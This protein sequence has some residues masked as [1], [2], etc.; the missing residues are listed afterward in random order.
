MY[1]TVY[2]ED[3]QKY[4]QKGRQYMHNRVKTKVRVKTNLENNRW[5]V[6]FVSI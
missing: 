3:D 2:S 6:V 1:T 5:D 4:I